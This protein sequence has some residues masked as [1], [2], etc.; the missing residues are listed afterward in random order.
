LLTV[1]KQSFYAGYPVM[2]I[3]V[4]VTGLTAAKSA[5]SL[6]HTNVKLPARELLPCVSDFCLDEWQE[7]WDCCEGNK[8]RSI[9]PTVGIL[10]HSKN[11]PRYES[12]LLNRLLIGH[13]RLTHSCLLCGDPPPTCQSCG[14]PLTVPQGSIL[15]VTLFCLKIN[16]I[17][18]AVCPD[19]NCFLYINDFV[20]CYPSKHIH[21]IER[22][23]HRCL[24]KLQ[25]WADTNGFKFS[26][27]KTV[28]L[29]FCCLRKLHPDS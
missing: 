24:N 27:T 5:L 2:L 18:K 13:S 26:T 14:I 7:I 12:V 21:I 16:S 22:H 19:V 17:I 11:M 1:A 29:N 25:E 20:I 28:C 3:F 15:S 10:K 8:L 4:S 6:P 23:L 9:Y